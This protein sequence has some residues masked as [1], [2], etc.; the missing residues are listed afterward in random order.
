MAECGVSVRGGQDDDTVS[1]MSTLQN[2]SQSLDEFHR[3]FKDFQSLKEIL[4]AA[5]EDSAGCFASISKTVEKRKRDELS[6]SLLSTEDTRAIERVFNQDATILILGQTNCGKSSLANELL[7]GRYLPTSEIPC[8]SRIVNLKYSEEEYVRIVDSKD[9]ELKRDP[10]GHNQR[11]SKEY[12]VVSEKERVKL[13]AV[14]TV[15]EVGLKNPL[16]QSGVRLVDAPGL[17]END[18]LDKVVQECVKGV[19][20][21]IIYVIDGNYGLRL[22]DRRILGSLYDVAPELSI[23]YICNKIESHRSAREMD[24]GSDESSSEDEE[25]E[26]KAMNR[27]REGVFRD[28]VDSGFVSSSEALEKCRYYHSISTREIRKSRKLRKVNEYSKGFDFMKRDFL[29]FAGQMLKGHLSH[30][31]GRLLQAQIHCFD[32]FVARALRSGSKKHDRFAEV[33]KA[34][35]DI[36]SKQEQLKKDSKSLLRKSKDDIQELMKKSTHNVRDS[37]LKTARDMEYMSIKVGDT[38]GRN[39]LIDQ[40]EKQVQRLVIMK[41]THAVLEEIG[42]KVSWLAEKMTRKCARKTET[43]HHGEPDD[44]FGHPIFTVEH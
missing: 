15:V 35:A 7:G 43:V 27:K 40:L 24:Q 5:Y 42:P 16:L 10:L 12:I 44:V 33:S 28:L 39:E 2:E 21:L 14:K 13:D 29:F 4:R 20:Q 34:I 41:V 18:A 19:L 3:T 11:I 37:I 17:C 9:E 23:F 31:A 1:I 26:E 25:S 6:F 22:E 8:T 30:A 36:K 32:F 38:V